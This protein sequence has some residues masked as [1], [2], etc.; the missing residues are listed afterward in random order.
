MHV[1][2]PHSRCVDESYCLLDLEVPTSRLGFAPL[3]TPSQPDLEQGVL[4]FNP[5]SF[6]A[7]TLSETP[8]AVPF[9]CT[10]DDMVAI[11]I[12]TRGLPR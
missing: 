5:T 2:G 6:R 9:T 12:T 1:F 8:L 7:L 4:Q 10:G 11:P 3:H